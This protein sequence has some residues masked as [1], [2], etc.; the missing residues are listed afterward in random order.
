MDSSVTQIRVTSNAGSSL[1]EIDAD[2]DAVADA[3]IEL[4]GVDGSQLDQN[5]FTAG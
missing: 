5:D 4:S 3:E 2:A 1:I